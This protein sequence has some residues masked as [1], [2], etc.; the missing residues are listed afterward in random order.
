MAWL[1]RGRAQG[2][3]EVRVGLGGC[4]PLAAFGWQPYL[5]PPHNPTSRPQPS[6]AWR[7]TGSKGADGFEGRR[8]TWAGQ[9]WALGGLGQQLCT[10]PSARRHSGASSARCASRQ[11]TC[12]GFGFGFV[13]VFV[14][15][16]GFGLPGRRCSRA[17]GSWGISCAAWPGR[18]RRGREPASPPRCT[19][20]RQTR[21]GMPAAAAAAGYFLAARRERRRC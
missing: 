19:Q 5:P 15:V 16:F 11:P 10:P 7:V 6:L 9:R 13:F 18:D 21:T 12:L 3:R 2:E 20:P 1:S 4:E 14:F 8:V 17:H